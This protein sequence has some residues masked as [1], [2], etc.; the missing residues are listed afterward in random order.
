MKFTA[1]LCLSFAAIAAATPAAFP[2]TEG[3][4]VLLSQQ[5]QQLQQH[6]G[7]GFEIDIH[8]EVKPK[9][10]VPRPSNAELE[11]ESLFETTAPKC[12]VY[13]D[14]ARCKPGYW[15]CCFAGC[16]GRP[17]Q[18]GQQCTCVKDGSTMGPSCGCT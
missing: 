14:C 4:Q 5:G 7:E 3:A 13:T 10:V 18:G 11:L 1:F 12:K 2:D 16:A 9:T 15:R 6:L 17:P 8:V